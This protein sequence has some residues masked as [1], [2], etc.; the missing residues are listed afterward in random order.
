MATSTKARDTD[1]N[2]RS[3]RMKRFVRELA[4][5]NGQR[6]AELGL[7]LYRSGIL[8]VIA[9]MF[10]LA[11]IGAWL[12]LTFEYYH[13]A[14][15]IHSMPEA[16]WWA[17]VTMTTT[18]YGDIV[19]VTWLGRGAGVLLMFGGIALVSIFSA[20]I[21]SVFIVLR[22]NERRGLRKVLWTDH[23]LLCGWN[24]IAVSLL[25][26][27]NGATGNRPRI[28]L[29]NQL[30]SDEIQTYTDHYP[31][32]KLQFVHGDDTQEEIL[33]R[34]NV[35]EASTIIILSREQQGDDRQ[36]MVALAAR[37]LNKD[38]MIYAQVQEQKNIYHLRRAGV[39]E[40]VFVAPYA[41]F[42]LAT[43]ALNPGI[44]QVY[45]ELMNPTDHFSFIRVPVASNWHE[46]T[47]GEFA[48]DYRRNTGG[49]VIGL[50]EET[51]LLSAGDILSHDSASIDEF[52]RRKFIEAGLTQAELER[53]HVRLN[54]P[55]DT[56]LRPRDVAVA[57]PGRGAKGGKE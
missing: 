28:V 22:L 21:S 25:D 1:K 4:L 39:D 36:I 32:L 48:T 24:A 27:I 16:L 11:F 2:I 57:L 44:P 52:I 5:A 38:A 17:I 9:F 8:V 3:K 46:R 54:P 49:Q 37:A 29:I 35:A 34:A 55:D 15:K 14:S 51:S 10:I 30:N 45:D 33:K 7:Q 43:H 53:E 20:T 23:L 56:K 42:L 6:L 19:P 31:D 50:I 47:Y 41:G 13:A 12:S 18:G 26:S 40:V